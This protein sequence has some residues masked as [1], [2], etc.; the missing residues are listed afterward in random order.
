MAVPAA[1]SSS[2]GGLGPAAP[3]VGCCLAKTAL[4]SWQD[5]TVPLVQELIPRGG[6]QIRVC[7]RGPESRAAARVQ[8]P[9][10]ASGRH[11]LKRGGRTTHEN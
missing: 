2:P 5:K 6:L 11:F 4:L 10:A 3:E 1:G 9:G 7:Q 8:G